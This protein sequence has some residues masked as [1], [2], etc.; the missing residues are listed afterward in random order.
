MNG[1]M[2]GW[3]YKLRSAVAPIILIALLGAG[4]YD[5]QVV[6]K[7]NERLSTVVQGEQRIEAQNEQ[8]FRDLDKEVIRL[9]EEVEHP[10][11]HGAACICSGSIAGKQ[12]SIKMSLSADCDTRAVADLEHMFPGLRCRRE[13]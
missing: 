11:L 10:H 4:G 13:E 9:Q 1:E 12:Q 8:Q 7:A 2:G 3:W 6:S 5:V